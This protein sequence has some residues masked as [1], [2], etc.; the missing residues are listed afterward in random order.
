MSVYK[1]LRLIMRPFLKT[2]FHPQWLSLHS[3]IDTSKWLEEVASGRVLDV[4]CAGAGAKN[5]LHKSCEYIGLDYPSTAIVM[6]KTLPD[7]FADGGQLPIKDACI[8]TVLLLE[9]LEHIA[10]AQSVVAEIHRVLKPGGSLLLSMPFLYPI[11]DAPY[12]YQRYTPYGLQHILRLNG[13]DVNW[14]KARNQGFSTVGLLATISCAD[15]VLSSLKKK[16]WT[17]IFIPLLVLAIPIINI[18]TWAFSFFPDSEMIAGGYSV[19]ARKK[20]N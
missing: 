11:H 6:Y 3:N 13:F 17:A 15:A 2:P 8:D 7:V 4:G 12:D 1:K 14:I 19:E 18:T 5:S 9:V 10:D 20:M 16:S